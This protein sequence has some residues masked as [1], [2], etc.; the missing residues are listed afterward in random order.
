MNLG[1]ALAIALCGWIGVTLLIA[2]Y[3][4]A[5]TTGNIVK[6][7]FITLAAVAIIVSVAYAYKWPAL[8]AFGVLCVAGS[9]SIPV[10][11]LTNAYMML[12]VAGLVIAPAIALVLTL[13]SM[14]PGNMPGLADILKIA[15]GEVTRHYIALG[16][17][18]GIVVLL[19]A[20]MVL[21]WNVP[22]I[23]FY[24]SGQS[25][26]FIQTLLFCCLSLLLT[27]PLLGSFSVKRRG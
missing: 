26:V 6:A 10:D 16:V 18:T 20:S 5:V 15:S 17:A 19:V 22:A 24:L 23:R 7:L 8:L 21:L 2:L 1:K 12:A 14:R 13:L 27:T 11:D 9:L 4:D 3:L 25:Y